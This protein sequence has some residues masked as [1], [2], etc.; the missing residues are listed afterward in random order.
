MIVCSFFDGD[1]DTAL[2]WQQ[3][4]RYK[5][6]LVIFARGCIRHYKNA[7]V[8]RGDD[9]SDATAEIERLNQG[10]DH[11]TLQA[12]HDYLAA[13]WRWKKGRHDPYFEDMEPV[14]VEDWL[15]WLREEVEAWTTHAP[16]IVRL[17][18]QVLLNQ[19]TEAGYKAEDDL[20]EMLKSHCA[21]MPENSDR[22]EYSA[23]KLL[24]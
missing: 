9:N 5:E 18:I 21:G 16:E 23:Q 14:T 6:A 13:W 3:H 8:M 12:A 19:N 22:E 4:D 20:Q 15:G 24:K 17:V 1:N 11:R 2:Q 7:A 10:F